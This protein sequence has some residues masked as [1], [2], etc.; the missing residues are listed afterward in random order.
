MSRDPQPDLVGYPETKAQFEA[1]AK[2]CRE[3]AAKTLAG[4]TKA[5]DPK[6]IAEGYI[7]KAE[8]YE[9]MAR[10]FEG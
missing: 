1:G 3:M 7:L 8:E 10:S 5:R 2:F 6:V 4:D 9:R